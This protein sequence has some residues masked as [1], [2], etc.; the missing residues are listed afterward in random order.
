VGEVRAKKGF[1]IREEKSR[2]AGPRSG[3][4]W[5]SGF[6]LRA[7]GLRASSL[8]QTADSERRGIREGFREKWMGDS[9]SHLILSLGGARK[10]KEK[11]Y[12]GPQAV[13]VYSVYLVYSVCSVRR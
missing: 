8:Q 11:G 5:D 9:P 4:D 13:L 12:D 6:R 3:N 7:S 2:K 10:T 1:R